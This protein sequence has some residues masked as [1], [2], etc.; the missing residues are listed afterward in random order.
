MTPYSLERIGFFSALQNL[1]E[2]TYLLNNHQRVVLIAHSNGPPTL[3]SFLSSYA[4][5]IWISTYIAAF[6]TLSGNFFRTN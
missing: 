2:T 1:I 6:I 5:S 3:Y 4:K